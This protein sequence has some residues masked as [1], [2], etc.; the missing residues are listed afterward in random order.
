MYLDLLPTD[1]STFPINYSNE[2]LI[3]LVGS[4]FLMQIHEKVYDIKRDYDKICYFCPEFIK[5]KFK[6]F[7]WARTVVGSRIFGLLI[8]GVKTD[9]LA[10]FADMLNHKLPKQTSWN[11]IDEKGGFEIYSL[12]DIPAGVEVF[13]SYG[14][15]CNS[16][17]LLNYGFLTPD[18]PDNQVVI[19][20]RLSA[21]D[22]TW[23]E[24]SRRRNLV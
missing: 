7:C 4:P 9:I 3:E 20:T 13:D 16:R 12:Q 24:N 14:K 1:F 19:F 15:K 11:Y 17:Y 5:Y 21:C 22:R 8:K 2:D 10:P 23:W 6:D 18:N